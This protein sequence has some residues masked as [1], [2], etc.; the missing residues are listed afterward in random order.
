[1]RGLDEVLTDPQLVARDMIETVHHPT[2][3]RLKVLGVPIKLSDTPGA[4]VNPPPRLGEHT[5][6]V[7]E[8]ML[9]VSRDD[10][11]QLHRDAVIGVAPPIAPVP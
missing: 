6:A 2:A 9:G 10:I 3:G 4:V 11:A 5:T 8:C 1:V 7:L